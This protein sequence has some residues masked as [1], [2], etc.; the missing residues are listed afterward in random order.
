[1][2]AEILSLAEVR[3]KLHGKIIYISWQ[4]DR[5]YEL[6]Q[7]LIARQEYE[8]LNLIEAKEIPRK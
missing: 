8:M 1:M 4:Q 3:E 2:K 5:F 7:Y 6:K